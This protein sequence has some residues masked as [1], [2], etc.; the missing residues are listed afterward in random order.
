MTFALSSEQ[1]RL[2]AASNQ[3]TGFCPEP[4]SWIEVQG[5]RPSSGVPLSPDAKRVFNVVMAVSTAIGI[6]AIGAV[7]MGVVYT[8]CQETG[9]AVRR[10]AALARVGKY[11]RP[12]RPS[13]DAEQATELLA[14]ST[15]LSVRNFGAGGSRA[16]V[17]TSVAL[18]GKSVSMDFYLEERN[19]RWEVATLSTTRSCRCPEYDPCSMP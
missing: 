10:Y 6:V 12:L 18:P 16:C 11:P 15:D 14:K 13:A 2:V 5:S 8:S 9:D 19:G 17:W 1:V 3:S 7:L 4:E